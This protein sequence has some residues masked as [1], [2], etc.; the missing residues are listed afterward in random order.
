MRKKLILKI[1]DPVP[2]STKK[3]IDMTRGTCESFN[4]YYLDF[5]GSIEIL[6][7]DQE[8]Y[9]RKGEKEKAAETDQKI[10]YMQGRIDEL[11]GFMVT[12]SE[13]MGEY[14]ELVDA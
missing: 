12:I 2:E 7:E 14:V 1:M 6:K 8:R 4:S 13:Q 11:Y 5:F 9:T 3:I 10:R